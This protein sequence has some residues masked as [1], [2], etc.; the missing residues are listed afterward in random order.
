[1]QILL[2][3]GTLEECPERL[4]D[5][6]N[7]TSSSGQKGQVSNAMTVEV[8]EA[9]S[10]VLLAGEDL[11]E[12]VNSNDFQDPSEWSQGSVSHHVAEC[13]VNQHEKVVNTVDKD[14]VRV[15]L[16][17]ESC[18]E[19][20]SGKVQSFRECLTRI[21]SRR[22]AQLEHEHRVKKPKSVREIP[23]AIPKSEHSM[24]PTDEHH[25]MLASQGSFGIVDLGASQSV[26]GLQ[27]K[28]EFLESLPASVR[29]RTYECKADMSFRF[30]N[31][32]RIHCSTALVA[33]IG[34]IWIKIAL[35][36]SHTPFLI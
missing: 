1:M 18:Q 9:E 26:M 21:I 13:F 30:G 4:K 6:A 34:P 27:Q 23:A 12:P 11:W 15:R 7:L 25:T 2:Q 5:K 17:G 3:K 33:P 29:E 32:S 35:V 8:D 10:D 19:P 36:A 28:T 20:G 22:K 14:F 16:L 24:K 31:N